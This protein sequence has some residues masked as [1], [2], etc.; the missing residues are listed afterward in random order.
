MDL[1]RTYAK[2]ITTSENIL[3]LMKEFHIILS[4]RWI[5]ITGLKH[6]TNFQVV[7]SFFFSLF[8]C[9]SNDKLFYMG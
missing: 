2:I 3:W 1:A 7:Y 8:N 6:G 5:D 4:A 9:I